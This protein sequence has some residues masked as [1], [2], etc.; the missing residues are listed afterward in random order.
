MFKL[1]GKGVKEAMGAKST[2]MMSNARYK[3]NKGIYL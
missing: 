1:V 3:V 2:L